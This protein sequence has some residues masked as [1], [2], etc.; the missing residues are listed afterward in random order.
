M[1]T[2]YNDSKK[3]KFS[4]D[5]LDKLKCNVRDSYDYFHDNYERFN[6]FCRFVFISTLNN[7]DKNKLKTLQ[8]P[9]VTFN[10]LEAFISRQ[11]GEFMSQEPSVQIRAAEGLNPSLLTPEFY[12]T[13]E[14]LEAHLR[15]TLLNPDND[16]LQYQVYSDLLA[17]GF[18]VIEVFPEHVSPT[19]PT[20]FE[21]VIKARR[22]F[23]PCLVGFDP[24]AQT[25]HKGD[26]QYCFKCYPMLLED[27]VRR[28]GVEN[29]W[30][31]KFDRNGGYSDAGQTSGNLDAFSWAYKNGSKKIV[32]V[33]EYYEK[34]EK[35]IKLLKLSDGQVM[36]E[37][38]YDAYLLDWVQRMEMAVPAVPYD[39]RTSTKT[40]ICRYTICQTKILDYEET[41]YEMLPLVFVDGNSIQIQQSRG[42]NYEQ[43]T[44]PYVYQARHAQKLKDFAGQTM[45]AE[46][47]N[48]QMSKFVAPI[49]G[50]PDEEDYED[51]YRNPQQANVIL[52]QA[53]RTDR[54]NDLVPPP[55]EV[56]RT[57]TPAVVLD[58]FHSS[59]QLMQMILGSYDLSPGVRDNLSGEAIKQGNLSTTQTAQPYL[60]NF[61]RGINRVCEIIVNLV[62]K[63]YKTPRT[64]P[65]RTAEGK[66]DYKV[67]N[68][69]QDPNST[70][71]NYDPHSLQVIVQ[72]GPNAAIQ[73]QVAMQQLTDAAKV[74]PS[75]AQ[76]LD[77][78]G[79]EVIIENIDLKGGDR[80]KASYQKYMESQQSAK[81]QQQQVQ[82]QMMQ[83]EMADK[84][85][86][87]LSKQA[88]AQ[89]DQSK[90]ALEGEK[91]HNQQVQYVADYVQKS[92]KQRQDFQLGVGGLAIDKLN[93]DAQVMIAGVEADTQQQKADAENARTVIEGAIAMDAHQHD[94]AVD[95]KSLELEEQKLENESK[96]L[97]K[98]EKNTV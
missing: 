19:G 76:F 16:Q 61:V 38:E 88:R 21:Q 17:G 80:L 14:I 56:Q 91:V 73:R 5:T 78:E 87:V 83:L 36:T 13:M 3:S 2:S 18:S 22:V 62:P 59:D 33:A 57:E 72:A 82:Q 53:F 71:M 69:E 65:I 48:M 23:N 51:A 6:D 34:K 89:S 67:I 94:K 28:F 49:E 32:L 60:T 41:D 37:K 12:Q 79:G 75:F 11:R 54:P 96:K 63:Y 39:T 58:A 30:D 95:I 52:Y 42:G 46:I 26:G 7:A 90:I 64:I 15:E 31:I 1:G 84:Q 70:M 97:A 77:Q 43:F 4:T 66:R 47:E 10:I 45:A 40:T 25:S 29:S 81:K 74:L 8:K 27:F 93:S 55:R 98:Q 86:D 68:Q 20:A 9:P 35:E 50:M 85:A 44:R 92:E 24:M